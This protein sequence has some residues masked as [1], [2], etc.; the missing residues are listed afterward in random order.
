METAVKTIRVK[1]VRCNNRQRVKKLIMTHAPAAL[2]EQL[3]WID[4]DEGILSQESC[5]YAGRIAYNG[6]YR[7]TNLY[8]LVELVE[9]ALL[10]HIEE[11]LLSCVEF[12]YCYD[13]L[14]I[15]G[16]GLTHKYIV[17]P[18]KYAKHMHAYLTN[19]SKSGFMLGELRIIDILKGNIEFEVKTK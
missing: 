13:G 14:N 1:R 8:H 16:L 7:I 17:V 2:F 5:E 6:Q 18:H 9:K 15:E 12:H 3:K 19:Y 11:T 10:R 4:E